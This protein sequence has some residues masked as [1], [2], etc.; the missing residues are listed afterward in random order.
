MS[1]ADP[2]FARIVSEP[3]HV[4]IVAMVFLL[5]FFTWLA[6]AQ[7]VANDRRLA[8][9]LAP[10][11]KEFCDKVLAWPDVV[12]LE[13]IGAVVA[14]TVLIVWSLLLRAPL[15]GPAGCMVRTPR[16]IPSTSMVVLSSS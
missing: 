8:G 10:R 3:D 1:L 16:G 9:G 12:Y 15:E 14:T 7:A 2:H 6:T 4:P 13:L 11:E 5:G